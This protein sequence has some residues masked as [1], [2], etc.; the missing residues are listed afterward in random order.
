MDQKDNE[1]LEGEPDDVA[2]EPVLKL[3]EYER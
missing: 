3:K 1:L 2:D